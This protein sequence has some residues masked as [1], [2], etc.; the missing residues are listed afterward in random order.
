MSSVR[1]NHPVSFK[2]KV[3][4]EALREETPISILT[5]KYGI[6]ATVTSA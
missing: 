2:A 1:K 5:S 6:H 4:L 3:V